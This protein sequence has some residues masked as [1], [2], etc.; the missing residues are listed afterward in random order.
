MSI[1]TK[2][3]ILYFDPPFYFTV[4]EKFRIDLTEKLFKYEEQ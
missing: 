4:L 1:T 3:N 2:I